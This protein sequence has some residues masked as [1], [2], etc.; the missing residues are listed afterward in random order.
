[1]EAGGPKTDAKKYWNEQLSPLIGGR[2][3][4]AGGENVEC[5]YDKEGVATLVVEL[6]NGEQLKLHVMADA[7]FNGPGWLAIDFA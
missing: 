7:E 2:I 6:Q 1:M 3:I 5:T 4:E